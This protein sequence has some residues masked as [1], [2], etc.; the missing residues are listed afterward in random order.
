MEEWLATPSITKF[1]KSH[2][3]RHIVSR[4]PNIKFRFFLDTPIKSISKNYFSSKP[5][6][7]ILVKAGDKGTL[8]ICSLIYTV[9]T[10]HTYTI[11][12]YGKD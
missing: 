8:K 12:F 3:V 11:R 2:S 9:Y 7:A 10:V 1:L 6:K 5:R 4:I